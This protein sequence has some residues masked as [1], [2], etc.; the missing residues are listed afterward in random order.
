MFLILKTDK[1]NLLFRMSPDC[2]S[3][4]TCQCSPWQYTVYVFNSFNTLAL[5]NSYY[6]PHFTDK[7]T[8]V[9]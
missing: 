3:W 8:E 6:H 4:N 5:C 2:P 1:F 7:E 9:H